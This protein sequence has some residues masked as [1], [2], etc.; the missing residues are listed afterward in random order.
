M[1]YLLCILSLF[2]SLVTL[3]AQNLS[4]QQA[5]TRVGELI[6]ASDLETLS[7]EL[8]SLKG[9]IIKPLLAL[10]EALVAY[11][12]GRHED[13]NKA[14][15]QVSEYAPELGSE[16]VFNMSQ[17]SIYNYLLLEEYAEGAQMVNMI[18]MTLPEG[19]ASAESRESLEATLRWMSALV[20]KDKVEII[21]PQADA[22]IPFEIREMGQG[23]HIVV[24][25]SLGENSEVKQETVLDTGCSFANFISS[26]A[27]ERLGVEILA[28]DI[29]V[30]GFGKGYARL[31]ILKEAKLGEVCI[32]NM[33][34]LVVDKLVPDNVQVE[35]M[36]DVIL[37]T[38]VIRK[39]GEIRFEPQYKRMVLP[40]KPSTA[41]QRRNLF[42]EA[43]QYFLICQDGQEQLTLH[44]DT[45]NVKTHLSSR[46]FNRFQAKIEAE[47]GE[48]ERS[49]S[50]GFGGVKWCDIRTLPK[51]KLEVDGKTLKLDSIAVNLPTSYEDGEPFVE[52]HDGS[53]GADFITSAQSTT[54]DL[55]RM[56]FRIDK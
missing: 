46:Y 32:K 43:G 42:F 54:L 30:R 17:L 3:Q 13:S 25:L 40:A 20:Q 33:T 35:G 27:A 11:H 15:A 41:P 9:Q 44:F 36:C 7:R 1:R 19:E 26:K 37:G 10:A 16:V 31:G 34:F 29:I 21:R 5:N 28:E 49:R 47:G 22:T 38:H 56:F 24:N 55:K 2:L 53:A 18:L 14:I 52:Q 50:G 45:G 51:V 23:Q 4:P 12:E 48:V 39:L 6:N 8:P